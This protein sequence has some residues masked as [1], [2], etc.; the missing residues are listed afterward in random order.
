MLVEVNHLQIDRFLK[1][2]CIQDAEMAYEYVYF[3]IDKN[4]HLFTKEAKVIKR[5][6]NVH[7]IDCDLFYYC[8]IR[9]DRELP[10]KWFSDNSIYFGFIENGYVIFNSKYITSSSIILPKFET[11]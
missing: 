4:M 6:G 2:N 11:K 8:R 10:F 7:W 5:E 9:F 1:R 3:P